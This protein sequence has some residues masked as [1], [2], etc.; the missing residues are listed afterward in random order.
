[1]LNLYKIRFYLFIFGC[2]GTR[3]LLT[4]ASAMSPKWLLRIFGVIALFPV[5][6]WFYLIFIG[7]RDTGL[8]VF[9]DI[10]WWKKLRPVHMLLWALFAY[11]AIIG[12]PYAWV[13]LLVDTLFGASAFFINH[14][15]NGNLEKMLK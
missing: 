4:L 11:L 6:G 13:V 15:C 1:M 5:I 14:W 10:I 2:I 12:N 8:E 3:L 9:G 7:V